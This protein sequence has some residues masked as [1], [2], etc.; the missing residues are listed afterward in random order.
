GVVGDVGGLAAAL[1]MRGIECV[2]VP[3]TLL[4]QVDASVGGK[5]AVDF[6]GVKNLIGVFK[7]PST[8][9]VDTNFLTTL[10]TRE[11]KCGLGEIVKHAALSK[12]LFDLLTKNKNRLHDLDFLAEIVPKNIAFKAK[13]VQHDPHEKNLR[14]CLNLGHTTAHAF[15]LCDK[16]LSHGEYV[17]VGLLFEAELAKSRLT[18]NREYMEQLKELIM[19]ALGDMPKLPPASKAVKLARMDKKNKHDNCVVVTAPVRKGEYTLLKIPFIEYEWE[20]TRIQGEL[21]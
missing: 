13:I 4:A 5:T 20:L 11:I 7:Q 16:K 14:K 9:I 6:E 15:E 17:L 12:E 1:Y 3:T 2:N 21:C 19:C 8:V 18:H 10:T